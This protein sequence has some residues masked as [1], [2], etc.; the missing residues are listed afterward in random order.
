MRVFNQLS[1]STFRSISRG[2]AG[3]TCQSFICLTKVAPWSLTVVLY[4]APSL[5]S[6]SSGS[7]RIRPKMVK[8]CTPE[9]EGGSAGASEIASDFNRDTVSPSAPEDWRSSKKDSGVRVEEL[10]VWTAACA[11]PDGRRCQPGRVPS[12]LKKKIP[13]ATSPGRPNSKP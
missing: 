9:V 6:L 10:S 7:L 1:S 3:S 8:T 11:S 4:S 5:I 12:P 13:S 2:F